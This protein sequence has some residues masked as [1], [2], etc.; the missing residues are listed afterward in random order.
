MI[1]N[2]QFHLKH[3]K[4]DI[5]SA[6]RPPQDET[7]YDKFTPKIPILEGAERISGKCASQVPDSARR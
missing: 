7:D 3:N 5:K 6:R 1:K 4:I 2:P